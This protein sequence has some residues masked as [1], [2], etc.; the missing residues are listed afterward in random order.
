MQVWFKVFHPAGAWHPTLAKEVLFLS[1][2]E[3]L[4]VSRGFFFALLN[5]EDNF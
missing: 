5:P 2:R 4:H 3:Q 1:Q